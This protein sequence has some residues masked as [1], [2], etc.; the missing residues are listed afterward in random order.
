MIDPKFMDEQLGVDR[1]EIAN[2]YRAMKQD[3]VAGKAAP[4]PEPQIEFEMNYSDTT[5]QQQE[6]YDMAPPA[7]PAPEFVNPE[8]SIA[9][10]PRPKIARPGKAFAN[11]NPIFEGGPLESELLGWK[12]QFG[13]VFMTEW[14]GDFYIWRTLN[15]F[16]YKEIMAM[17]NTNEL[18]REELICEVAVLFPY[19]YTYETMVNGPGGVPS[20][21]AENIMKKSAFTRQAR[22]IA[23]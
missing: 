1:Q 16:E 17:P 2:R 10:Q 7:P 22:V 5:T 14:E 11:D 19:N 20:M 12:K 3:E 18:M 8:R 15:R 6:E 13:K 9:E 23:L 4:Q 21:L